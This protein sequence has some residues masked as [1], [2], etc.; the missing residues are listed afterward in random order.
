MKQDNLLQSQT[1]HGKSFYSLTPKSSKLLDEGAARI[2]DFP[3]H[4]EPWDGCWHLVTYTIPEIS[5]DA[6]DQLRRELEWMGYGTLTLALWISPH[7]HR[8]EIET[9]ARA[10]ILREIAAETVAPLIHRHPGH[11]E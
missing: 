11:E 10:E 9:L 6:R 5:R 4:R 3:L 8:H 7:D 1:I 2:F